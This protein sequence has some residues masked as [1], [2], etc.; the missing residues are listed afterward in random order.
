L[1]PRALAYAWAAPA[2]LI[3]LSLALPT[4]FGSGRAGWHRGVLEVSG[5]LPGWLLARRL[6]VSGAVAAITLGHVVLAVSPEALV[7]T[8]RHERAHV[9]QYE[10]WGPLFLLAYPLAS[11]LAWTRH[12]HP[13]RD[14]AFEIAA[15]REERARR[16]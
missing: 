9:R 5:G 10:C 8:R 4:L 2:T 1:I 7:A 11:L 14:N 13:Y 15:R 12:R 16:A 6:P 3:G